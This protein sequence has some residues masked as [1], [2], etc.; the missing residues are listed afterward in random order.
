MLTLR[1]QMCADETSERKPAQKDGR[2]GPQ[3]RIQALP[4]LGD[5]LGEPPPWA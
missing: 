5:K 3:Q 4:Q 1:G 2:V